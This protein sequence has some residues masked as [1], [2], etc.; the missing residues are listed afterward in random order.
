MM[1][2][3]H[4]SSR[5]LRDWLGGSVDPKVDRHV[6]TCNRCAGT[7]EDIDT[8]Q[9]DTTG[10]DASISEA[11]ATVL[12]PPADLSDRLSRR[13]AARLDSKVMFEIVSDLFGAGLETSRLLLTEEEP[14]E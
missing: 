13:V 11:L 6:E 9:G 2:L 10:G 4:P 7:I 14:R 3:R 12:S 1:V 5:A 8:I